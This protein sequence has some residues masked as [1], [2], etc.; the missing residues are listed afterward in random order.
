MCGTHPKPYFL[1][2]YG[3]PAQSDSILNKF[4]SEISL[5]AELGGGFGV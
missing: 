2:R 1:S 4:F 3:T 5:R